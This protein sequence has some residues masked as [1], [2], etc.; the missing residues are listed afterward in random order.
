MNSSSSSSSAAAP[1]A[2]IKAL[3]AI[4][5]D[6]YVDNKQ[7]YTKFLS[8][9]CSGDDGDM[10]KVAKVEDVFTYGAN[11][12]SDAANYAAA[13]TMALQLSLQ[14]KALEEMGYSMLFIRPSDILVLD[15]AG[16]NKFILANLSQRVPLYKKDKSC[17][18]LDYPTVYPFPQEVCAPEVIAMAAIP[19]ISPRSA[20]YYSLAVLCLN[21]LRMTLDDLQGT[22][23]FYF[24]E[25]C[26][27][28]K[29]ADRSLL[30]F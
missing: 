14:I 11:H 4:D 15:R 21:M 1:P 24:L 22:K 9:L 8:I 19:F 29:P 30:F 5:T 25:R 16:G 10:S 2:L 28:E 20:T 3:C 7:I 6:M 18:L 26:L 12:K 13:E 23:L 27:K 17:F